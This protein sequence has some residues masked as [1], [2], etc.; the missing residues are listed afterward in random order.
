MPIILTKRLKSR[1]LLL[2]GLMF[3]VFGLSLFPTAHAGSGIV[4][5]IGGGNEDF[6]PGSWC[7]NAYKRLIELSGG[8]N[9][10][11]VSPVDETGRVAEYLRE[12]GA[13]S[14]EH[15]TIGT[16][17][18][19]DSEAILSRVEAADAIFLA[20]RPLSVL[21]NTW[22]GSKLV[23]TLRRLHAAGKPFAAKGEAIRWVADVCE[24]PDIKIAAESGAGEGPGMEALRGAGYASA[25]SLIRD[26]TA[27]N[28]LSQE[29]GLGFLSG[30]IIQPRSSRVGGV[31]RLGVLIAQFS[32]QAS[33]ANIL[34]IGLDEKTTLLVDGNDFGLV[35][36]EGSAIFLSRTASSVVSIRSDFSPIATYRQPVSNERKSEVN[37]SQGKPPI[38]THLSCDML[39]EGFLYNITG[40]NI[41]IIPDNAESVFPMPPAHH[42]E[43]MLIDGLSSE[44]ARV[45]LVEVVNLDGDALA[46][47]G[48]RLAL[49]PGRDLFSGAIVV[50][51]AFET[52]D[53]I[54][55][56]IGGLLWAMANHPFSVGILIDRGARAE[57]L[58]DGLFSPL[59]MSDQPSILILDAR[60]LTHRAYVTRKGLMDASG[61]RQTVAL[62]GLT[63]HL[64]A[65]RCTWDARTGSVTV[66]P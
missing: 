20:D 43:A 8:G 66:K 15:L 60:G 12:I 49:V 28:G 13:R 47:Q 56:R 26:G 7:E 31:A 23:T 51:R 35:G 40:H 63:M 11:I 52:P 30:V 16:R 46:L 58:S 61:P 5:L 1:G 3:L 29:A 17:F 44:S 25:A 14:A 6:T 57:L 9:V 54:E 41:A 38:V 64:L 22:Q 18:E 34:G 2:T 45:G 19:A 39:T 42:Y 32:T 27:G 65:S 53:L 37:G 24:R 21:L 62:A 48:G 50:N 33:G 59:P 55:N 4:L 10:L 36:G